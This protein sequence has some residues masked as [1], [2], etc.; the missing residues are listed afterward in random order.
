MLNSS[1][2]QT[3]AEL[4]FGTGGNNKYSFALKLESGGSVSDFEINDI[5]IIYRL[6]RPK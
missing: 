2:T 5:T 4:K 1:S 6:K 3:R